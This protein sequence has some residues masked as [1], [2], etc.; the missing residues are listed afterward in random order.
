M[1]PC[2]ICH[3]ANC[4]SRDEVIGEVGVSTHMEKSAYRQ[5]DQSNCLNNS[6]I[7]VK[8]NNYNFTTASIYSQVVEAIIFKHVSF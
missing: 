4:D 1:E 5:I 8:C 6:Q 2:S 3:Y 7:L